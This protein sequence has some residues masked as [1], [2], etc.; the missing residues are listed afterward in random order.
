LGLRWQDPCRSQYFDFFA[1]LVRR[2]DRL[3]FQDISDTRIPDGGTPGY[4][5]FNLRW[6]S[7]F[8]GT[9]R[10]TLEL[11]NLLDRAY[12]VHGSG[13]DGAGISVNI[14]YERLF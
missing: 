10:I 14:G 3:N 13:V 7:M 4:A 9:Q 5:T 11:E 2:Q 1:W 12:R 6:S 8:S